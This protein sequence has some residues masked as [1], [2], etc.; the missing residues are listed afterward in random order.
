MQ[1]TMMA[2]TASADVATEIQ[3]VEEQAQACST[4]MARLHKQLE[5]MPAEPNREEKTLVMLRLVALQQQKASLVAALAA[6]RQTE[7]LLLQDQQRSAAEQSIEKAG[8]GSTSPTLPMNEV[9]PHL[10]LYHEQQLKKFH[11][12][13]GQGGYALYDVHQVSD[14]L[15]EIQHESTVYSGMADA[16]L[17][18]FGLTTSGATCQCRIAYLHR[19]QGDGDVLSYDRVR[20]EAIITLLGACAANNFPPLLDVTDGAVH[21]LLQLHIP[22]DGSEHQQLLFWANLTPSEAY[23]H[24]ARFLHEHMQLLTKPDLSFEQVP[25]NLQRMP[26]KVHELRPSSQL[27]E[28]LDS[29]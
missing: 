3:A 24:Q 21:H 9:A 2:S 27:Q 4:T 26:R 5:S 8:V 10:L 29:V 17:A 15:W 11:V 18:P 16:C 1:I 25:E 6:L 28:Q 13:F 20:G 22:E 12:P 7:M 19:R 23:C 14:Q